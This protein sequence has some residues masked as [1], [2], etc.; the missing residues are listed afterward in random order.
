[1]RLVEAVPA[2]D[3]IPEH[4]FPLVAGH[5]DE[6]AAYAAYKSYN[7]LIDH[8]AAQYGDKPF[9]VE[10]SVASTGA[11]ERIYTFSETRRVVLALAKQYAVRFPPRKNG[12]EEKVVGFL[13]KSGVDFVMNDFALMRL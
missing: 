4:Y 9:L 10:A 12:E 2:N 11:S 3:P 6:S 5:Q 8:R 7:A 1:M 13:A